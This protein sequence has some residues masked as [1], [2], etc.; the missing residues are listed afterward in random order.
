M[1]LA[2][3]RPGAG[4]FIQRGA[5]HG[6]G[7]V[8]EL[9]GAFIE[10]QPANDTV[11]GKIFGDAG[12]RDTQKVSELRFQIGISPPGGAGAAELA[13]GN[14]KRIAGLYIII[15]SHVIV[16]QDK[17]AGAGGRMFRVIELGG[18]ASEQAAELHFEQREA[19]GEARIAEAAASRGCRG[20]G[21]RLDWQ[22]WDG[23][24]VHGTRGNNFRFGLGRRAFA[25]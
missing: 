8:S 11:I 17:D 4:L 25:H 16:G 23:P 1:K 18:R 12:F 19:R 13:D 14:A 9:R 15:G 24:R 6:N 22:P 2:M 21:Q 5:K 20:I 10:L 7:E 3:P